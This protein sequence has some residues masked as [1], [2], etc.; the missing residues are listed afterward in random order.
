LTD[1]SIATILFTSARFVEKG[2][3]GSEE[4]NTF[5]FDPDLITIEKMKDALKEAGTYVGNFKTEK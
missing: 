3:R 4:I 1:S 2:F 5:Y